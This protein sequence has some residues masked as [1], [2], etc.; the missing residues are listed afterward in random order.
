MGLFR[1]VAG[2]LLAYI[3]EVNLKMFEIIQFLLRSF[4]RVDII[5]WRE[6]HLEE[7]EEFQRC[8]LV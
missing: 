2:Q 8:T 3:H 5:L 6:V 1:P 7:P 4:L